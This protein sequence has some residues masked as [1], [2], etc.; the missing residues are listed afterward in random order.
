MLSRAFRNRFIELHVED[1]PSDELAT[2]LQKR[3]KLPPSY[4]KK[5]V[6]VMTDLQVTSFIINGISLIR[7]P[8]EQKKGVLIREV[9]IFQGL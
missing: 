5:M 8:L 4:S 6:A 2:I 7:T 1:I 9:S 3:C